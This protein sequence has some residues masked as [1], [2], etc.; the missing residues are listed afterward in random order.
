MT[1]ADARDIAEITQS[2]YR[3]A[4]AIDQRELSLLDSIFEPGATVHYN[5]FGLKPRTLA[6]TKPWLD[7]SLRIHRVTQHNMSTPRV[8]LAGD[9]ASSTTY[10]ILAHAQEKLDGSMSVVTQHGVYV[11]AWSRTSAGWRIRSRRLDNLFIVGRFLGPNEVK[12]F[13]KPVPY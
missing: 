3:Y 6:E 2:I 4:W 1:P 12:S 10:G 7:A 11:D 5:F 13:S 9:A 8:E